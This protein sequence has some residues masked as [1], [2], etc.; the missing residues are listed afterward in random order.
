METR[1]RGALSYSNLEFTTGLIKSLCPETSH[2]DFRDSERVY[3]AP[4]DAKQPR[5]KLRLIQ[6]QLPPPFASEDSEWDHPV[7]V[8]TG[9]PDR[10]VDF[11]VERRQMTRVMMD[12]D[13]DK[14]LQGMGCVFEFEYVKRGVRMETR[15]GLKIEIFAVLKADKGDVNTGLGKDGAVDTLVMEVVTGKNTGP[16]DVLDFMKKLSPIVSLPQKKGG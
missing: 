2:T 8:Y 12:S 14:V 3:S 4:S 9:M 6:A 1:I 5:Y 15:K 11:P 10:R 16:D 13:A 7:L